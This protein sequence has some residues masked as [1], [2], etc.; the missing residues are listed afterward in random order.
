MQ[1]FDTQINKVPEGAPRYWWKV[2]VPTLEFGAMHAILF[3]MALIPLTMSRFSIAA[4]SETVVSRF[5]PMN[6]MLRI[7]I[8][9][10]YTMVILVFISTLL[11]FTFFGLLCNDGDQ[12]F[13]D[14]FKSEIMITGYIIIGFLL[15]LGG[16]AYFRHHMPYELF[17]AIHH[18]V[19]LLYLVTIIHTFDKQQRSGETARS[20]TFKWFSST[21]VYYICDRAAMRLNHTYY[22]PLVASSVVDGGEQQQNGSKMI[23]L[24]LRRPVLFHFKPG[25]FAQLRLKEI[26]NHWHPFSIASGPGSTCLEFYIEVFGE[27]SWTS[28]LWQLLQSEVTGDRRIEFEVMGP[29]GTPLAKTQDYSHGI[30]VGAGTGTFAE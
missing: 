4:L 22:T 2:M 30:A 17:Y 7:H 20:Q 12:E 9:L 29:Y 24:R 23:I 28:K 8:H 25:Q 19:F 15:I 13:C 5:V 16:T 11:F 18:L 14:K 21:L 3:Q 27:K 6:R 10:G 26:D 1:K